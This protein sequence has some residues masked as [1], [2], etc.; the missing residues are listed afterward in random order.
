MVLVE[1]DRRV[2]ADLRAT[3]AKLAA[4]H[5]R[6]EN[7]DAS[8]C[9]RELTRRDERFDIVFLDPP[10]SDDVFSTV[11][12]RIAAICAVDASVYVEGHR[13]LGLAEVDA[14]AM[15]LDRAERAGDVFYHLLHCKNNES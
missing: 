2:A 11:L 12:P 8:R 10:F 9:I 6:I 5:V 4:S 1:K 7:E 3:K 15:T 14:F 13:P